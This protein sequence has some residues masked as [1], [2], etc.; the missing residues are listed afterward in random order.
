MDE[1]KVVAITDWPRLTRL[2]EVQSFL[3]FADFYR[4]F[5][6]VF[7][8]LLQP[9]IQPTCK[10]TPFLWTPAA[11]NA[12]NA[13]KTSFLSAPVSVHPEPTCPFQVDTDASDIAI[14]TI[15]SQPDDNG[16]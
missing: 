14:G 2:K 6:D 12:L 15:L 9:L 13:L 5:I 16:T 8:S 10:D 4:W 11:H 7:S 3:G 1:R